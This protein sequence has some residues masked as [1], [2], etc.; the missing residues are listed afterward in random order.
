MALGGRGSE[1]VQLR[2]QWRPDP[3][4]RSV[5]S[6][7]WAKW[8]GKGPSPGTGKNGVGHK[9]GTTGGPWKEARA[10]WGQGLGR[11]MHRTKTGRT[12]S[13]LKLGPWQGARIQPLPR[14]SHGT[15][16]SAEGHE[17]LRD[18]EGEWA[19][20]ERARC[21]QPRAPDRGAGRGEH[22]GSPGLDEGPELDGSCGHHQPGGE[23]GRSH[24]EKIPAEHREG[25]GVRQQDKGV[26]EAG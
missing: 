20:G 7:D 21:P 9:E 24:G 5:V 13:L 25:D 18:P 17:R 19:A 14:R 12:D 4:S 23:A 10:W 3:E 22:G 8:K 2:G 6:R 11:E 15:H 1:R 16:Q 26:N